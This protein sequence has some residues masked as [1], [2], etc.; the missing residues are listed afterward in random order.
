MTATASRQLIAAAL[1]V[2]LTAFAA[3][4]FAQNTG[5]PTPDHRG[6]HL[7]QRADRPVA[8]QSERQAKIQQ[9]RAERQTALKAKL[10]ISTEQE[11]AWNAFM[12]RT[13][14]QARSDHCS[15]RE[16]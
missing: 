8:L 7:S 5:A 4:S 3:P 16:D 9:H 10:N 6:Q 12:A 15:E 14:P 11:P 1:A 2:T 13:A